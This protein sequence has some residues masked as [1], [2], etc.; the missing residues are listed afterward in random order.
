MNLNIGA[1]IPLSLQLYDG[2]VGKFI[3]ARLYNQ[4]GTQIAGSPV[5]LTHVAGGLYINAALVMPACDFL[6]AAYKVYDDSGF[7]TLS[8]DYTEASDKFIAVRNNFVIADIVG[9]I[10]DN[11]EE[12]I[13]VVAED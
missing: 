7:T 5:A 4:A 2:A 10:D 9:V 3:R 8:G 6:V 12:L 13:G 11:N 1:K